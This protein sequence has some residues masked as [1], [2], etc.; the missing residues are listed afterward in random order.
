[1]AL[2]E[3]YKSRCSNLQYE[4]DALKKTQAYELTK[5]RFQREEQELRF[6]ERLQVELGEQQ[7]KHNDIVLKRDL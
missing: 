4:Y 6:Q 3:E 1:M 2:L 7:R 5:V